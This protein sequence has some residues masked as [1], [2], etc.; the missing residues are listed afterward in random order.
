MENYKKIFIALA[1]FAYASVPFAQTFGI[2]AGFNLSTMLSK[3]NDRTYRD[4]FKL[5]PGF[6]V[7]ATAEV[8][9]NKTFSFEPAL[10]LTTKGYRYNQRLTLDDGTT[11]AQKDNTTLYYIDIPLNVKATF[12]LGNTKPYI[13]SGP[14]LGFGIAGNSKQEATYL[15]HTYKSNTK[16]NWGS[17]DSPS[18]KRMDFGLNIGAGVAIKALA[19]GVSC[20]IGA[21]NITNNTDKGHK[22]KNRGIGI[23]IGYRL[24][25]KH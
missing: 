11:V 14:Y 25:K 1:L 17:G 15:G 21:A 2:K 4:I 23:S 3:D 12:K 13:F 6:H 8:T 5:N 16:I 22:T 9:L 24:L 19:F 18:Y 7:G 20:S 10:L